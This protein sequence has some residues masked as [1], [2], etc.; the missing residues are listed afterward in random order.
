MFDLGKRAIMEAS[1]DDFHKVPGPQV[2][3]SIAVHFEDG[4]IS[5][6]GDKNRIM[7]QSGAYFEKGDHELAPEWFPGRERKTARYLYARKQHRSRASPCIIGPDIS[8]EGE[9]ESCPSSYL[10]LKN[11]IIQIS[12]PVL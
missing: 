4:S 6:A 3:R 8:E 2:I 1:A 11:E 7:R 10:N 12:G 9:R 5:Q